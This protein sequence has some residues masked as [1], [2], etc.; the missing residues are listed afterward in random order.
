MY[1][2]VNSSVGGGGVTG[3]VCIVCLRIPYD[4]NIRTK[5]IADSCFQFNYGILMN[6]VLAHWSDNKKE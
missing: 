4:E 3:S 5:V 2:K 1:Y 6:S